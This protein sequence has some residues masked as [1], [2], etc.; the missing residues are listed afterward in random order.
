MQGTWRRG[1]AA[2]TRKWQ[3]GAIRGYYRSRVRFISIAMRNLYPNLLF[4]TGVFIGCSVSGGLLLMELCICPSCLAQNL[5]S[6]KVLSESFF[7]L[8][9][10]AINGQQMLQHQKVGDHAWVFQ[11]TYEKHLFFTFM[12]CTIHSFMKNE[13]IVPSKKKENEMIA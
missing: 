10:H 6:P 5:F 3:F 8:K 11:S 1:N 4:P 13:M 9:K 7:F 12:D 2:Q